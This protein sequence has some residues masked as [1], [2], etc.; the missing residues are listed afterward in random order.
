MA[1]AFT[2]FKDIFDLQKSVRKKARSHTFSVA[3]PKVSDLA[4]LNVPVL[5]LFKIT[6]TASKSEDPFLLSKYLYVLVFAVQSDVCSW[7]PTCAGGDGS[8]W[9][10]CSEQG[11]HLDIPR[12]FFCTGLDIFL[13]LVNEE[14]CVWMECLHWC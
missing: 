1:S 4:A 14:G 10:Q 13:L 11:R 8:V 7:A 6:F 12:F 9:A 2:S 5:L 3:I